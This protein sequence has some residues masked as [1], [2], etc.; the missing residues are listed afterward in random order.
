MLS[1]VTTMCAAG[2]TIT[3]VIRGPES[4]NGNEATR[5]PVVNSV[6]HVYPE[7]TLM[8]SLI[9]VT[10]TYVPAHTGHKPGPK[11]QKF[12]PLPQ[13]IREA[14][15]VQ[16]SQGIPTKRILKGKIQV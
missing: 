4:Q 9:S 14:V 10:I 5:S 11:E 3:L 1:V 12:L 7:C 15:S 13:S 6:Q 8:N 2:M 16:L